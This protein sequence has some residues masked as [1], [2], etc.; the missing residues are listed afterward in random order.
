MPPSLSERL[1]SMGVRLGPAPTDTPKVKTPIESVVDGETRA[2]PY[3]ESFVV[4]SFYPAGSVHGGRALEMAAPLEMV[5]RWA[6][7]ERICNCAPEAFAFI[8]T[9]TT[10]LATGSGTYAFMVGAGRYEPEGFRLAQYFMRDPAEEP[11]L[12]HLLDEFLAPA[13]VL[14]SFNGKSFDVPLLNARYITNAAPSPLD[15][16]AQLDILH[17]ARRVWRDRLPDRSLTYLEAHILGQQRTEEDTPGWMIPQLYF[18]YIR[19]GDAR[20]MKGV[21]YHN[22]MDILSMAALTDQLGAM[23]ADPLGEAVQHAL[24]RIAIGRLH[25]ELGDHEQAIA[26]YTAGLLGDL[27]P[28]A[29]HAATKNLAWLH[30][31]REEWEPAVSLW[32]QAAAERQVYAHEELAKYFEHQ[33]ANFT[34]A[35]HWV[36]AALALIHDKSTPRWEVVQWEAPLLHRLARLERKLAGE[37]LAEDETTD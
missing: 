37:T 22:L 34:E 26:I 33:Q 6:R 27:S 28:E 23:L 12:L 17:L 16:L 9:E 29:A 21:F 8:D 32:W 1:K 2:T 31:R 35:L 15:R 19:E 30:R 4:E 36:Q 25:E 14:V 5:A 18:D 7:D 24:D 11:A 10:G 13:E 3:G 20:P